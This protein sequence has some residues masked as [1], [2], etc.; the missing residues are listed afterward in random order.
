MDSATLKQVKQLLQEQAQ[1]AAKVNQLRSVPSRQTASTN[2]STDGN[3]IW[4][5][6]V[7]LAA[8]DFFLPINAIIKLILLAVI[9]LGAYAVVKQV[10]Q[11]AQPADNATDDLQ[12][13]ET[14]GRKIDEKLRQIGGQTGFDVVPATEWVFL[15]TKW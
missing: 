13:A 8:V 10:D 9:I 7:V 15:Q 4:G 5:V 3:L 11:P 12:T 6:G 2:K 1:V 14:N